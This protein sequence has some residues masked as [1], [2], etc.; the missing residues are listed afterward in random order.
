MCLLKWVAQHACSHCLHLPRGRCH[1]EEWGKCSC[2]WRG[3]C[4]EGMPLHHHCKQTQPCLPLLYVTLEGYQS[5]HTCWLPLLPEYATYA[6]SPPLPHL[7][8]VLQLI[9]VGQTSRN[10]IPVGQHRGLF[11]LLLL[12]CALFS[13]TKPRWQASAVWCACCVGC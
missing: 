11:F 7:S 13:V 2:I 6:P 4:R 3:A 10:T 1:R 5:S 8:A 9:S 12:L